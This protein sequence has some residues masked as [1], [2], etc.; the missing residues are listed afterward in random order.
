MCIW[1]TSGLRAD[2]NRSRRVLSW[3]HTALVRN[4]V[5]VVVKIGPKVAILGCIAVIGSFLLGVGRSRLVGSLKAPYY[6][7]IFRRIGI[8]YLGW[9][10]RSIVGSF[11]RES[12][13]LVISKCMEIWQIWWWSSW[14]SCAYVCPLRPALQG[15]CKG[16]VQVCVRAGEGVGCVV[17]AWARVRLQTPP[18]TPEREH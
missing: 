8:C 5:V 11:A 9:R 7:I 16:Y 10:E 17:C 2:P 14:L 18:W 13:A 15:K 6:W 12:G 3:R 4:S 1:R